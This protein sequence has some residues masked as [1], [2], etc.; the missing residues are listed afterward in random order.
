[1]NDKSSAIEYLKVGNIDIYDTKA[2]SEEFAKRFSS[3]GNRY[4]SKITKPINTFKQYLK[5]IPN[6]PTSMFMTPTSSIEIERLIERL[7]NLKPV[8]AM[9][10][11]PI[12]SSKRLN[13]P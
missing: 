7:P 12:Y 8:K 1:M 9:M 4:A 10:I 6:N 3:V 5:N 2:I 11:S 13:Q